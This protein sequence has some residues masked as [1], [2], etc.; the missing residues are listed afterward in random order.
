MFVAQA[1]H[2]STVL[3]IDGL[4]GEIR[5]SF[6]SKTALPVAP[7]PML[8]VNGMQQAFVIWLPQLEAV[9]LIPKPRK[10]R[11]I[12]QD[13]DGNH[14]EDARSVDGDASQKIRK[15]LQ[16]TSDSVVKKV[17]RRKRRVPGDVVAE[18][19]SVSPSEWRYHQD[20]ASRHDHYDDSYDEDYLDSDDEDNDMVSKEFERGLLQEIL[21]EDAGDSPLA[22]RQ[23]FDVLNENIDSEAS[24]GLLSE[25]KEHIPVIQQR[26][27]NGEDFSPF[28]KNQKF[29]GT[30]EEISQEE[31]SDEIAGPFI[32]TTSDLERDL[33]DLTTIKKDKASLSSP[34]KHEATI[35]SQ[36]KD[37][38]TSI[39]SHEKKETETSGKATRHAHVPRE[40]PLPQSSPKVS[41]EYPPE[42]TR[43][44]DDENDFQKVSESDTIKDRRFLPENSK[45]ENSKL[46]PA[47]KPSYHKRSVQS[48]P[49]GSQCVRSS[50]DDADSFVALLLMK[51]GEGKQQIAEITE[52]SPIYLGKDL[53]KS[54]LVTL[55]SGIKHL[56]NSSVVVYS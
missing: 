43:E 19:D 5:W 44:H 30:E 22:L 12:Q 54:V 47:K 10:S 29:L 21:A 3:V 49:S 27:Y 2:S 25:S 24:N 42:P 40:H 51:D 1:N 56:L 23:F 48:S 46:V 53:I 55:F 50:R 14:G 38:M 7:I 52:E 11:Q 33:S 37:E 28:T 39:S 34:V 17:P 26:G 15:L 13:S 18:Y 9:T 16:T 41:K 4:T 6:H 45:E 36:K 8:G 32:D 20:I 31:T 35:S